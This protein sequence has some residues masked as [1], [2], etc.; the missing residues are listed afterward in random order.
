MILTI[1]TSYILQIDPTE[2]VKTISTDSIWGALFILV[3]SLLVGTVI[4]VKKST[5]KQINDLR[6]D[7]QSKEQENKGLRTEFVDYL[8]TQN[9][10]N[11]NIIKTFT[12][13]IDAFRL[14][15]EKIL[16]R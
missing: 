12:G 3:T 13:S 16:I 15:T 7:I 5:Q 2:A 6:T 4:Y 8:K 9:Q 14:V 11:I 1:L 10:E